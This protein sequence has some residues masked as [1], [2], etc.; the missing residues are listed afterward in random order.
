LDGEFEQN[1]NATSAKETL[2]KLQTSCKGEDKIKKVHLQTLR[3]GF[4]SYI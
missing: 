2:E 1:S 3:G 4:E